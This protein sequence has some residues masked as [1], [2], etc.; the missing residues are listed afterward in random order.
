MTHP[1]LFDMPTQG[2]VRRT[3]PTT[4]QAAA[5]AQHGGA[6]A[7]VLE[8]LN[9]RPAGMTDGELCASLPDWHGPTLISA[10]SRLYKRGFIS[11]NGKTRRTGRN[12]REQLV[13]WIN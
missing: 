9:L 4:S 6:E 2:A 13:W 12:G 11:Q 3:D 7:A 10:R 5:R 1:T 8:T